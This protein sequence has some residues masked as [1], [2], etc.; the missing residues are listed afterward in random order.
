MANAIRGDFFIFAFSE[1]A[2]LEIDDIQDSVAG[3]TLRISNLQNQKLSQGQSH[4]KSVL[5]P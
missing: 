3:L 2:S 5:F 1:Y 4:D